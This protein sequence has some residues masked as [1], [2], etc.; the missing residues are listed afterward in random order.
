V[1]RELGVDVSKI[2]SLDLDQIDLDALE[3]VLAL[4]GNAQCNEVWEARSQPGWVRITP[5][6]ERSARTKF[7]EA[8]YRWKAFTVPAEGD[9]AS[10]ISEAAVGGDVMGVFRLIA[11]GAN[12]K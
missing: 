11:G 2:R 6:A 3:C 5:A 7:I 12:M 8:K 10:S 1:H 4:G 9:I